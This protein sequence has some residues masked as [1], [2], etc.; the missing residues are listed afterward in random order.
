MDTDSGDPWDGC[1]NSFRGGFAIGGMGWLRGIGIAF[2]G[3]MI[4][5][6]CLA[7]KR[8]GGFLVEDAQ[9]LKATVIRARL[10]YA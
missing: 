6:R 7:Q 1:C 8:A 4:R 3:G 9:G 5:V 10:R 2:L